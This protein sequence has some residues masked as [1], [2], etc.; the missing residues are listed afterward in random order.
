MMKPIWKSLVLVLLLGGVIGAG[1]AWW[2]EGYGPCVKGHEPYANMV[3]RFDRKL[4]LAPDQRQA[5]AAV[6]EENRQKIKTL[7]AEV[8]PRFEEI[9]AATRT[10]IRSHLASEQQEKFDAMQAEWDEKRNSGR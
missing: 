4:N 9:R 2:I 7:R 10:A 5:I 6:L 1:A 3:E 8:H